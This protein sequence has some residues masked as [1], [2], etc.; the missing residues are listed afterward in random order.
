[1]LWLEMVVCFV[2]DLLCNAVCFASLVSCWGFR[3][4]VCCTMR[5]CELIVVGCVMLCELF[6]VF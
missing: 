6:C 4:Y 3:V 5:V 2:C 1:M